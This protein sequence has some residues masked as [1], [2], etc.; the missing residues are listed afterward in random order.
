ME[1]DFYHL[2]D[3]TTEVPPLFIPNGKP[4]VQE[5][6]L[7]CDETKSQMSEGSPE[8]QAKQ[9]RVGKTAK[10]SNP[11]KLPKDD[12]KQHIMEVDFVQEYM[13]RPKFHVE[14]LCFETNIR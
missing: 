3:E 11:I 2:A 7:E 12:L 8:I 10:L 1:N 14:N 9:E 6:A 5:T 13:V 4:H